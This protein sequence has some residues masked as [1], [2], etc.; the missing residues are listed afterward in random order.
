MGATSPWGNPQFTALTQHAAMHWTS[1]LLRP[2]IS[3]ERFRRYDIRLRC[4]P[5]PA[6]RAVRWELGGYACYLY[7]DFEW[8]IQDVVIDKSLAV[9][10]WLSDPWIPETDLG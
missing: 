7:S 2:H 10:W 1:D 5:Q 8:V 9:D 4:S 3:R 6:M